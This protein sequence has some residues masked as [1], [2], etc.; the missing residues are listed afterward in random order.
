MSIPTLAGSRFLTTLTTAVTLV[1]V[2]AFSQAQPPIIQP[3]APGEPSR[4]ITAEE[5]SDLAGIRYTDGEALLRE[6]KLP[7]NDPNPTGPSPTDRERLWSAKLGHPI[8]H[9]A[10][11]LRLDHLPT[12]S[13]GS[14]TIAENR[15]VPEE[16]I[17]HAGLAMTTCLL[18]PSAPAQLRDLPDRAIASARPRSASGQPGRLD[19]WN[20]DLCATL[21]RG[22]VEGDRV[23]GRVRR[24]AGH[25]AID[26]PD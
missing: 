15:F 3:G 2:A 17:L 9:V 11:E 16:G 25:I 21:P 5:A 14:Q 4:E 6:S 23:I 12:W 24:D 22:V 10:R 19:G 7:R 20:H 1:G 26:G 8:Q 18:L 13:S